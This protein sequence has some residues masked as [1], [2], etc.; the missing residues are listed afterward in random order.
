MD[1]EQ[2]HRNM[3]DFLADL[4]QDG[5]PV[6]V[7]PDDNLFDEGLVTSFS[8]VGMIT[9]LEELVGHPIDVSRYGVER[10]YT[11]GGLYEVVLAEEALHAGA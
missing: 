7:G 3:T 5:D 2:F 10:F 4:D 9:H 8:V 6:E 11:I 1:R